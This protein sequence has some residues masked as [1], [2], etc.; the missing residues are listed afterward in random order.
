M[1]NNNENQSQVQNTKTKKK[2]TKKNS[3]LLFVLHKTDLL[4]CFKDPA[5]RP[6]T[7]SDLQSATN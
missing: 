6:S 5:L 3:K 4:G 2:T 1:K 7:T